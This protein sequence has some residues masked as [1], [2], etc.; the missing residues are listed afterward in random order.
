M[1]VLVTGGAGFIGSNVVDLLIERGHQVVV[2]DD[3]SNGK[4]ENVNKAAKF[5]E[6]DITTDELHPVFRKESPDAVCHQAAQ[7]NVRH[8]IQ[9]PLVDAHI[10]VHGSIN[11]FECCR[12]FGT[13]KVVFASSGG[14]IYGDPI[15]LPCDENHPI[16]PLSPYAISKHAAELML[17]FY[18]SN[19]GFDFCALRYANV[20]GPRQDPLGEAGV[21]A[22]FINN[23]INSKQCVVN[24]DGKQTRDFVY[25]GD[26]ALAN[27]LAL[28]KKTNQ[29]INIGFGKETSVVELFNSIK[30]TMKSEVKC[31]HGPEING[32]VNRSFLDI[33]RA[34]NVLGWVP[35]TDLS[36]G[37][38][39]TV[40]WVKNE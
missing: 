10:N 28:E 15:K 37:L 20:Y 25:V 18:H 30:N 23:I 39:K 31:R 35:K 13:K 22:I 4:L 8:S 9:K 6:V 29:C 32:E 36:D 21:I 40:E 17:K 27:L 5:Y 14:A 19:F 7:I 3:L 34:K 1:K 38:R 16:N 2:V 26:V 33:E 11:V 24:G 12:T